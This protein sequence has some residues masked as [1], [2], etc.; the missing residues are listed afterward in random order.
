V[1]LIPLRRNPQA[2]AQ[3]PTGTGME[4]EKATVRGTETLPLRLTTR[5]AKWQKRPATTV[6]TLWCG[7]PP[8][9]FLM[10]GM[11]VLMDSAIYLASRGIQTD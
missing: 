2:R 3:I 6:L 11:M 5:G 1:T 4:S 8:A 10:V 7:S 9:R